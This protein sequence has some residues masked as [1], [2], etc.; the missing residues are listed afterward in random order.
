MKISIKKFLKDEAGVTAIEYGLIAGL[1]VAAVAV[2]L[3]PIGTDLAAVFN[4][5]GT[6][7]A[8]AMPAAAPAAGG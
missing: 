8:G 1:I 6:L 4:H 5:I 3:G 7:V 2:T